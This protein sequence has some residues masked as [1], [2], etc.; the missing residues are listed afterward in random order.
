MRSLPGVAGKIKKIHVKPGD[1][2]TKDDVLME[3]ER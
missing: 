1:S 2:V 3:I